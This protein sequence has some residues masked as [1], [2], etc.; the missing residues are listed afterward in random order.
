MVDPNCRMR[1]G[2]NSTSRDYGADIDSSGPPVL[3]PLFHIVENANRQ[4]GCF[5]RTA[6]C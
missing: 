6:G 5:A 4:A 2:P 1:I 3:A